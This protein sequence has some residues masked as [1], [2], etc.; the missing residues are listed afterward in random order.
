MLLDWENIQL[1]FT[2][3]IGV[4]TM[5][6]AKATV[7]SMLLDADFALFQAKNSG[8]NKVVVFSDTALTVNEF[9]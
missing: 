3:S 4:A 7:D 8:R 5:G 2:V 6:N 9:D 1:Q